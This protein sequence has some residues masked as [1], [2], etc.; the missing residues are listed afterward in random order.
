MPPSFASFPDLEP[1]PTPSSSKNS[2]K[3]RKGHKSERRE[4]TLVQQETSRFF[5]SDRKGDA[6][7]L[8]YGSIA[9]ENIPKYKPVDGR[10]ILGLPSLIALSRSNGGVEVG[11]PSSKKVP[12]LTDAK[13]RALL[14]APAKPITLSSSSQ[15]QEQDGF[16]PLPSRPKNDQAYRSITGRGSDSDS[17]QSHSDAEASDH[18]IV[19]S[20]HQATIKALEQE[21]TSNPGSI[22]SWLSLLARMLSST[23]TSSK[24]SVKAR[25][26]ITLSVVS[27]AL[28]YPQ[29]QYSKILR[30]KYLKAGE[31]IWHE[32]KL[33]EE[34]EAALSV[35]GAEIWMEW[36]EWR[37][38]TAVDGING[39]VASAG[40]VLDALGDDISKLRVFWRV[41]VA[42]GQA[43]FT[44]TQTALF[45]AQA[46]LTYHL[47]QSLDGLPFSQVLDELEEF[48]ESEV[49]R[50]GE[51]D[52]K[53]W[54]DWIACGRYENTSPSILSR[55]TPSTTEVDPYRIWAA[56]EQF[57]D[58]LRL[59][60]RSIDELSQSDPYAT[61]FFSD[62]RPMLLPLQSQASRDA[63]RKAWL[64][65][66]G[67]SIPGFIKSISP[68]PELIWDDRWSLTNFLSRQYLDA[69]F[70]KHGQQIIASDAFAGIIVGREKQYN[71]GFGPVK[72]WGY[73]VLRPLE[74]GS[75]LWGKTDVTEL[76]HDLIRRVF[77]Q[78]RSGLDDIEWD[79]LLLAFEAATG[80]NLKSALKLSRSFLSSASNSHLR[81][82]THAMLERLRGRSSDARKIYQTVLISSG[83]VSQ[84][85]TAR[86]WWDWAEMDWL[87]GSEEAISVIL[88]SSGVVGEEGVA[89]LR[90]KRNLDD[91]AQAPDQSTKD[92][93]SWI[94][95]RALLNLLTSK[96]PESIFMSLDQISEQLGELWRPGRLP[97]ESLTVACLLMAHRYGTILKGPNKPAI[98]RAR[99]K[100]ALDLY[101]SNSVILGLFLEGEKGQAVWGRVRSILQED[102]ESDICKRVQEV[103]MANWEQGRWQAEVERT[104]SSL[105]AAIDS[106]RTRGSFI[107]W[108]IF[109]EFEIRAGELQRAKTLLYRAIGE[110]SLT[111]DFYLLAF[112]PLRTVFSAAELNAFVDT[113]AERKLRISSPDGLEELLVNWTEQG[114]TTMEMDSGED[115]DIEMNARELRRLK[116][117]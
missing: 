24:N 56:S 98:F 60:S 46:E 101:P 99:V 67:L 21:L 43:G 31:E 29:N 48:W 7:N 92:Q 45:Q 33:Q 23:P 64:S 83:L 2:S 71:S 3:S 70:P 58:A 110:C 19:L 32:S 41:A 78:L 51:V 74:T 30:L 16:L 14:A 68:S 17:S 75:S 12:A 93:E 104:R 111:K 97:H 80:P 9:A 108:R 15:Y 65:V 35:G 20:A 42:F 76:D 106:E 73:N 94:K 53:G 87:E 82:A 5:Y 36:L 4:P 44:Q 49:P 13:T 6:L 117:Y 27:R 25:S 47:P 100:T 50:F 72:S 54:A 79:T 69:I 109:L 52:A 116:P 1:A 11:P 86:L 18:E 37:I 38:R 26:E 8:R 61:I 77:A 59:P 90:A 95:L 114:T 103:W 85:G 102:Q 96:D 89:I 84:E 81:W 113:M 39:V 57:S 40:R 115:S 34:W 22:A 91:L 66:L 10:R 62:I 63:F 105:S 88:R 28:Q 107:I 55:R 112:G